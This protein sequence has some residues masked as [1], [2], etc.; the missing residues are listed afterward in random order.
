MPALS[1]FAQN[2]KKKFFSLTQTQNLRYLEIGSGSGFVSRNNSYTCIDLNPPA[3]I[4]GDINQWASLGLQ[5]NS[6]DVIIAFEVVEHVD[7]FQACYD[8]LKTGGKLY[9][10]TPVPHFDWVMKGLEFLGLN[11]KRTSPHSDL[12]YLKKVVINDGEFSKNITI[13]AG[14]S[15]WAVFTKR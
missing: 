11:Q 7:C 14:I 5:A 2:K 13:M 12:V 15:Q 10:T 3:D 9:L 4:V 6:Y 8:L 1:A